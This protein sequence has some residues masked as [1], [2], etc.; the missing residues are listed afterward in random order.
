M[1]ATA[2]AIMVVALAIQHEAILAIIFAAGSAS[3][4]VDAIRR[5]RRTS[6]ARK[7]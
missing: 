5:I 3:F 4:V 7:N 1:A 6:G 2:S